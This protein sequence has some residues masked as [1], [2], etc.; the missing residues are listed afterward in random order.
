MLYILYLANVEWAISPVIIDIEEFHCSKSLPCSAYPSLQSASLS[1]SKEINKWH[2]LLQVFYFSCH[3]HSLIDSTYFHSPHFSET[4][5]RKVTVDHGTDNSVAVA[6]PSYL[7][8]P[9]SFTASS[10]QS[11][12]T[13][14]LNLHLFLTLLPLSLDNFIILSPKFYCLS[15][16][17]EKQ[18]FLPQPRLPPPLL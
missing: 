18:L 10:I 3:I 15:F 11:A 1:F 5:S 2:L 14:N 16:S 17:Q 13:R 7:C 6:P 4:V 8:C 9:L 12:Q